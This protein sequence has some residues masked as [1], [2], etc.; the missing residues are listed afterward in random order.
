MK[1]LL[2]I[3][4]VIGLGLTG[5]AG[6][7][8]AA[9]IHQQP[10]PALTA[11]SNKA[12]D[13]PL[14]ATLIDSTPWSQIKFTVFSDYYSSSGNLTYTGYTCLNSD[15]SVQIALAGTAVMNLTPDTPVSDALTFSSGQINLASFWRYRGYGSTTWDTSYG[16]TFGGGTLTP[17][18]LGLSLHDGADT[19]YGWMRIDV[20]A[21]SIE[22]MNIHEWAINMTPNETILVGQTAAVPEPASL[23]LLA[24]GAMLLLRRRR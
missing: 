23:G 8:E 10:A 24:S 2:I 17:G 1:R 20:T 13:K 9:I 12:Y 21:N 6:L 11:S 14:N 3:S 19:Y 18:Y 15:S 5:L 16:G 7:S 22:L 4:A